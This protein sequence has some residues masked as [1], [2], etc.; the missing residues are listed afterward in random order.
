MDSLV[1]SHVASTVAHTRCRM[2]VIRTLVALLIVSW[3]PHFVDT[4]TDLDE[5]YSRQPPAVEAIIEPANGNVVGRVSPSSASV[6]APSSNLS[7]SPYTAPQEEAQ[8][9]PTPPPTPPPLT[10]CKPAEYH[11]KSIPL[12]YACTCCS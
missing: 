5:G 11:Y 8:E 10:T 9:V 7:S 4:H 6:P 3:Q 12:C 2:R 1:P